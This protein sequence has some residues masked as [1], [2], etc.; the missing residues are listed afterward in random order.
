MLKIGISSCFLYPDPGRVVFA[1]KTLSYIESDMFDYISAQ[2]ILPILIPNLTDTRLR[3]I[4]DQCDGFIFQGGTDMA[5]SNY[6]EEPIVEGKWLGDPARDAYELRLMK[7]AHQ[8]RKPVFGICRGMQVMNV[9]FGGSLYQDTATQLPDSQTHRD[10]AAYDTIHHEVEWTGDSFLSNLHADIL[11]PRVNSVH[12]QAIKT[13]GNGLRLIAQSKPDG[14]A[15]AMVLEGSNDQVFAVQ[16]HPEFSHTLGD[17]IIPAE[18]LMKHFIEKV[19][20]RK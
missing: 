11:N 20:E 4:V 15:E 9:Y 3:S 18:P 7:M 1:P 19:E 16:W 2:G 17:E 8:S 14:I 10:A 13:L 5:P 12:H 6:G